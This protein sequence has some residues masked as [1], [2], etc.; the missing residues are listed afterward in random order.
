MA[1]KGY[2]LLGY[3]QPYHACSVCQRRLARR[4]ESLYRPGRVVS[5]GI[6]MSAECAENLLLKLLRRIA[7][8]GV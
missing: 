3:E 5:L 4:V 1:Y 7:R 2:R 8:N 6:C